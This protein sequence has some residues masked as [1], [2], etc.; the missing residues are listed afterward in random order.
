MPE[1]YDGAWVFAKVRY[2]AAPAPAR[3]YRLEGG[4]ARVVF[5]KPQRAVTPGQSI[6][7]YE[8]GAVIGGGIIDD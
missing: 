2:G 8:G 5:E 6:V 7:F 1:M 3:I 4:M